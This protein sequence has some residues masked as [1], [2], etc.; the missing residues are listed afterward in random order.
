MMENCAYAD[1]RSSIALRRSQWNRSVLTAG[2]SEAP[3]GEREC[4]MRTIENIEIDPIVHELFA[5]MKCRRI[6]R[7]HI[8]I[9]LEHPDDVLAIEA[10]HQPEEPSDFIGGYRDN[11]APELPEQFTPANAQAF[12]QGVYDELGIKVT[13]P[14]VPKL[15]AEQVKSFDKFGFM[16][17]Y[18]PAITEEQYPSSFVKPEWSRY[19]TVSSIERIPLKGA[20]VAVETIAK[21]H[22]DDAKGYPNDRLMA[23]LKRTTRFNTSHDDLTGGSYPGNRQSDRVPQEEDSPSHRRRMEFHRELVQLVA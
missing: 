16:L 15:T 12:W 22:Y 6:G 5:Q 4:V 9:L 13:V 21:P 18:L 10:A 8:R 17:L 19:F 23:T 1:H 11:A 7:Q 3:R 20:W 2:S 14:S